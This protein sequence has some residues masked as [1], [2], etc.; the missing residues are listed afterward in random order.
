MSDGVKFVEL[1]AVNV[2]GVRVTAPFAELFS[3]VPSA[4][5]QVFAR[6]AEL[7]GRLD[8]GFVDCSLGEVD[9]LYTEV[10][11]A[12]VPAGFPAPA[13]FDSVSLPAATYASL[14][15]R[16]DES[17]I[18]ASFGTLLTWVAEREPVEGGRR[19][20]HDGVKL[21][22]GYLPGDAASAAGGGHVLCA[23]V[24]LR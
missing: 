9:G 7:E 2:V 17:G 24:V 8:V 14:S 5:Q 3:A 19:W 16:G 12:R 23:R 1:P 15:H 20:V 11:G 18:A 13:G 4:W 10:I 21:D 22:I 6:A